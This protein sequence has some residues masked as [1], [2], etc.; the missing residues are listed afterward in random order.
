MKVLTKL[1]QNLIQSTVLVYISATPL[2]AE[3]VVCSDFEGVSQD[4]FSQLADYY[5]A[6]PPA[7]LWGEDAITENLDSVVF[8][9]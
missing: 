8:F 9:C 2:M 7:V 1:K 6:R 5:E 4:S 3:R